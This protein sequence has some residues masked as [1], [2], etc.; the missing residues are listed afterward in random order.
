LLFNT[1]SAGS[2]LHRFSIAY[3]PMN[4]E[5]DSSLLDDTEEMELDFAEE[6][7]KKSVRD[8]DARRR[9]ERRLELARLRKLLDD[10]FYEFEED[11]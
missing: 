7:G 2:N 5:T 11:E 9:V 10:P 8:P 4:D 1:Q 6:S 3:T